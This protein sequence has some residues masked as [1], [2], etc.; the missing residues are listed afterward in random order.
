MLSLV[1]LTVT[2]LSVVYA[3]HP[4]DM[5]CC[6]ILSVFMLVVVMLN[7]IMLGHFWR[8]SIMLSFMFFYVFRL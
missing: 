6:I 4:I 2:I 5:L 3:E 7:V 1:K 8:M